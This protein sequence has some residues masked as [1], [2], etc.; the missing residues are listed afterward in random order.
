VIAA[1]HDAERV[2]I[3]GPGEAKY[4]FGKALQKHKDLRGRL[5]KIET[6][7]KMTNHQMAARVRQFYVTELAA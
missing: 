2:F 6:A 7:D 1:I 5:L 4:E 3:M